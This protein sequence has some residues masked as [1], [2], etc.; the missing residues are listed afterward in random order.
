M[1][2]VLL[3]ECTNSFKAEVIKGALAAEGIPCVIAGD[4]TNMIY[5]GINC[6]PIRI[7]VEEEDLK[8]AQEIIAGNIED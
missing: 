6:F 7:L 3:T 2:I 4:S 8:A 1:A 5:G